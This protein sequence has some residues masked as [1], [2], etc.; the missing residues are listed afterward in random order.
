MNALETA[1][2]ETPAT[3][4]QITRK[5][6]KEYLRTWGGFWEV[7]GVQN[8]SPA[9]IEFIARHLFGEW[10]YIRVEVNPDGMNDY[11]VYQ[12]QDGVWEWI[13]AIPA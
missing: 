10:S 1:N 11:N 5:A 13:D 4:E 6:A 12:L 3:V 9:Y 8:M 7:Q 2:G